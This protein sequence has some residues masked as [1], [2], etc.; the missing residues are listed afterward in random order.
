MNQRFHAKNLLYQVPLLLGGLVSLFPFYW[1]IVM[2]TSK[3]SDVFRYPPKVT[4]GSQL[5]TN[6]KHV[7][8]SMDFPAA[9]WNTVFI[10][11]C[12]TLLVLF[13]CSLAGYAFAKY[14]FPGDQLLFNILLVSMMIPGQLSLVPS[15]IIMQKLGW[16]GS[17]KALIVPGMASA[18]G[19]F[20]I[21]QYAKEA[22]HDELLN[23]GRIDGCTDLRLYWN[24]ALPVLRRALSFLG[25]FTFIGTWNDYLWPLIIINDA[26]K[27]TLQI[28]LSQLNGIYTTDYAMVMAG[29]C[30]AT[31][32]L[33]IV[34]VLLSKQFISDI[35]AGAIKA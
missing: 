19:I 13:F 10:S 24:V 26:K 17:F 35:A 28:A 5:W 2:S 25:I 30:L 32:P 12:H 6:M 3:T 23:A 1:I 14:R 11:S 9:F 20:W 16:I 34:F 33:I 27:Y 31:F 15:F 29:T 22:I 7:F 21:R 18:F 4:I 8:E